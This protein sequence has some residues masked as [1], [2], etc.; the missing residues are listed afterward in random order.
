M[1]TKWHIIRFKRRAF[2]RRNI[3]NFFLVGLI[4]AIMSWFMPGIPVLRLISL[5]CFTLGVIGILI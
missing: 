5:V 3:H 1:I 2:S 4:A